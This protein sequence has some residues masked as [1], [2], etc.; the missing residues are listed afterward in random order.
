M[1]DDLQMPFLGTIHLHDWKM[2]C[3][4]QL[5]KSTEVF[6]RDASLRHHSCNVFAQV[7]LLDCRWAPS[8]LP[9][10]AQPAVAF[11]GIKALPAGMAS[12]QSEAKRVLMF[13]QC[14]KRHYSQRS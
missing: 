8:L 6:G 13:N 11:L 3:M 14:V 1:V 4:S 12:W 7:A 2:M 5:G 10:C 9:L